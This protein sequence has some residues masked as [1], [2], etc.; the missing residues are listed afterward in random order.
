MNDYL[1]HDPN[2]VNARSTKERELRRRRKLLET[3]KRLRVQQPLSAGPFPST[4][5]MQRAD[6]ER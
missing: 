3:T 4:E 1:K 2:G 5:E 6:R